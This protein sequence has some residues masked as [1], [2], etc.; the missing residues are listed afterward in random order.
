LSMPNFA[1]IM[2]SILQ[3]GKCSA[4]GALFITCTKLLFNIAGN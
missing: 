4:F 3:F 2:N 1:K